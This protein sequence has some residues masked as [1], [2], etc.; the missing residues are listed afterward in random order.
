M[1]DIWHDI[2]PSRIQPDDFVAVIQRFPRAAKELQNWT[3]GPVTIVLDRSP[4]HLHPTPPTS[5]LFRVPTA[6]TG[7]AGRTGPLLRG[8]G[9]LDAGASAIPSAISPCWTEARNDEKIVAH[10]LADPPT[11]PSM[12]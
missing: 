11:I 1:S 2:S 6:T 10:P 9:P 3:R 5:V 8:D 7:P 4:S 12:I